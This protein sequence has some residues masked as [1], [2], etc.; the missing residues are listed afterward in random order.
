MTKG[1]AYIYVSM[2]RG[3][4]RGDV[5]MRTVVASTKNRTDE[6]VAYGKDSRGERQKGA[7]RA[8]QSGRG[9]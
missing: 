3:E 2:F 8:D 7:E 4:G 5:V 6:R 1:N 9:A